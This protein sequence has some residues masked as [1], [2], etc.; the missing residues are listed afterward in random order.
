M[1]TLNVENAQRRPVP[2]RRSWL[3]VPGM[4]GDAQ[5]VALASGT[6]VVVA[7]LEEFTAQAD[8]PSARIQIAALMALCREKGVVGAVRVNKLGEDGKA[9]LAGVMPGRPDVIFLPHVETAEHIVE[10]T[11]EISVL[12]QVH[13]I[14]TGSTEIV[15]TIE[16]AAGL[17]ALGNI[18]RAS[19]RIKACLLAAEDFAASLGAE[20]G[21]DCI[22]LLHARGQFLLECAAA[23]CV[24]IDCPFTFRDLPALQKDFKLA[25]RLG[26]KAKCVVFAEQVQIINKALTPSDHEVH[27][28]R[29]LCVAY[30]QQR[31]NQKVD[32][33]T[34]INAPTYNN[35]R[36]LLKRHEAF[37]EYLQFQSASH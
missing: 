32:I 7:D 35:A 31:G 15:P 2:L 23:A 4:D 27:I 14:P 20:R 10:L 25:R 1:S 22:E 19:K 17:L 33:T 24:A 29:E 5:G 12:E 30:E 26:F 8:R 3:F 6:D 13:G 28:A 11:Q 36:R 16:S 21:E 9:D 34:W 37:S 18:L